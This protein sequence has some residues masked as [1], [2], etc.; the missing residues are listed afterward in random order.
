[1]AE[2]TLSLHKM[3]NYFAKITLML[4]NRNNDGEAC[5]QVVVVAIIINGVGSGTFTGA[6]FVALVGAPFQTPWSGHRFVCSTEKCDF[7]RECTNSTKI[8]AVI[9]SRG[10]TYY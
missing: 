6:S 3:S 8:R 5:F 2:R 4:V 9:F 10:L 7:R 1:M